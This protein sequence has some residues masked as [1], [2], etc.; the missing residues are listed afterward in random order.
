MTTPPGDIILIIDSDSSNVKTISDCLREA[1]FDPA[2]APGG[3]EGV[4]RAEI[5]KPN[6]ILL[7]AMRPETEGYE[8][9]RLLKSCEVTKDIPVIFMTAPDSLEDKMRAFVCGGADYLVKPVQPEELLARVSIHI[10]LRRQTEAM[11]TAFRA[12][13]NAIA[14]AAKLLNETQPGP[15]QREYAAD[16]AAN[17][18]ILLDLFSKIPDFS[19][20]V[21][22][23]ARHPP[24]CSAP[25]T[26]APDD[27]DASLSNIRILLAEDH[28]ISQKVIQ[29]ILKKHGLH[30]D[31]ANNG[32]EAVALLEKQDYDLVLMDM[33]MPVMDGEE[34]AEIIRSPD[35]PVRNPHIPIIAL[36]AHTS[37][38]DRETCLKKG[39]NAYLAKPVRGDKL[40][41]AIRCH[42]PGIRAQTSLSDRHSAPAMPE[43]EKQSVFDKKEFMERMGDEKVCREFLSGI[44][45]HLARDIHLLQHAIRSED[46]SLTVIHAHN[47]K[48][49]AA[50][51]SAGGLLARAEAIECAGKSMDTV[52][53]HSLMA[54]L[55]QD[56]V[57]FFD[58]LKTS[59]LIDGNSPCESWTASP[60]PWQ[61]PEMLSLSAIPSSLRM[62]LAAALELADMEK[63]DALV[64]ETGSHDLQS[65]EILKK[66][67]DSFAYSE[68]I[69]LLRKDAGKHSDS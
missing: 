46:H 23:K 37:K 29:S 34:A 19:K 50:N 64:C 2:A 3:G 55:K 40:I 22:G 8:T 12:P 58:C 6:L 53:L 35:S 43:R 39:M 38:E 60:E 69:R 57:L 45:E 27:A 68:M 44:P 16:I 54:G 63:I 26:S 48:G 41:N 24:S 7:D 31:I 11:G 36:T 15:Q 28:L 9:C 33:Q 59:G 17:S 10:Q 62:E 30:A 32:R 18:H 47:L 56:A 65:F 66:M 13:L 61:L 51:L 20:P 4:K 67:A 5:L 52:R 42:L 1:G 14:N 21:P 25:Q 49:A